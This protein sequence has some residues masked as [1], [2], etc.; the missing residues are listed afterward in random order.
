MNPSI[1][2]PD[3]SPWLHPPGLGSGGASAAPGLLLL[4]LLSLN[5]K[6]APPGA[7]PWCLSPGV[8]SLTPH[9]DPA[10]GGRQAGYAV[11]IL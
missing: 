6:E 7:W 1:K 8:T 5:N 11:P 4:S 10:G 3:P 9:G 2:L